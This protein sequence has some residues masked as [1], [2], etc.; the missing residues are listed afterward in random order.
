MPCTRTSTRKLE[1][2]TFPIR[3]AGFFFFQRLQM[4][5]EIGTQR[6]TDKDD[7]IR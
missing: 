7:L 3:E 4:Q 6:T 2:F 5:T 1:M